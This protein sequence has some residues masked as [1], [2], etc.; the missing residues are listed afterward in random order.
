MLL[1]VI[2]LL[3]FLSLP[4]QSN[5][6][7]PNNLPTPYVIPE[8]YEVYSTIIPS[9]WP[10]VKTLLIRSETE[11]YNMC[12]RPEKQYEGRI[13]PAISDYV[14]QNQKTWLLQRDLRIDRPYETITPDELKSIFEQGIEGWKTFHQKHPDTGGWIELS[15]VG[16]NDDKTIAVVYMGYHCGIVCGG[17]EFHVLQK[18]DGKW[19]P[20]EW[21]GESC[22]WA[23]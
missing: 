1:Q 10:W 9:V 2:S 7:S 8:A 11:P 18:K 13:G 14:K 3:I 15:A 19:I 21:R 4:Y 22:S 5:P 23:S 17:G 12:L 16:F 20:L 6:T